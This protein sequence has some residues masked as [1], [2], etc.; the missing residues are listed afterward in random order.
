MALYVA[1]NNINEL[2][3]LSTASDIFVRF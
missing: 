2:T 3:S 1:S